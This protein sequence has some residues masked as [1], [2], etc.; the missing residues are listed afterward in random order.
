MNIALSAVII[1]VLLIPPVILYLSIYTG[2][3]P[4]AL[5]KFSLFEG[6]LGTAVVS[7][8][9]HALTISFISQEIRFDILIKL[10]GGDLKAI[11]NTISNNDL[12]QLIKSFAYY[13]FWLI[14]AM[15]LIGRLIRL[16]LQWNDLQA[17][18]EILNLYNRWWYLFNGYFIEFDGEEEGDEVEFDLVFI[19]AAVDT[20]EGTMI[21]SG[22]LVNFETKNGDLDRI[23]LRNTIR[24]EFKKSKDDADEDGG[25]K[26]G[27]PVQIP[28]ELFSISYEKVI[29]LNLSFIVIDEKPADVDQLTLQLENL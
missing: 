27:D 6:I 4:K 15:I 1:S 3:F 11:E 7:L 5:P 29:N 19:D 23:Y 2:R 22:L 26:P 20:N 24:R 13:N 14:L 12:E 18:H 9:I 28:G 25:N 16:L 21:Y 8:F 17:E 10:L